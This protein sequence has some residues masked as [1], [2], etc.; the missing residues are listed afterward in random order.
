MKESKYLHN[1]PKF[2][3]F[4][5]IYKKIQFNPKIFKLSK[6]ISKT[7]LTYTSQDSN[8]NPNP[9]ST[10]LLH[11]SH[12]KT[13]KSSSPPPNQLKLPQLPKL[14]LH[15]DSKLFHS[16]EFKSIKLSQSIKNPQHRSQDPSILKQRKSSE[17]LCKSSVQ[18]FNF[19]P[20]IEARTISIPAIPIKLEDSLTK[21]RETFQRKQEDL[22]EK[23]SESIKRKII[24]SK[25]KHSQGL[26]DFSS[27]FDYQDGQIAL[28]SSFSN[29][30]S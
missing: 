23:I 8:P 22:N 28:Y 14:P 26:K 4:T 2:S 5:N 13:Q 29:K 3:P 15:A 17:P 18:T 30:N 19:S 12:S 11:Q 10:S 16:I 25:R 7:S 27:G 6:L 9:T 20:L 24:Y 1:F 21:T